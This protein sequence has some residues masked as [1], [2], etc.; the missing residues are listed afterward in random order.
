M[1]W[2][3]RIARIA[4]IDVK[5]HVSGDGT[6]ARRSRNLAS[7]ARRMRAK[8]AI[9]SQVSAPAMTPHRAMTTSFTNG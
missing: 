3:I 8:R 4:G 2:S 6:P 7:Q 5:V 1:G 9:S